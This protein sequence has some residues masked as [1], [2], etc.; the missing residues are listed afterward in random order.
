MGNSVDKIM[1]R[2][3]FVYTCYVDAKGKKEYL[4]QKD[5]YNGLPEGEKLLNEAEFIA[6]FNKPSMD[7]KLYERFLKY[8][9]ENEG[10][11]LV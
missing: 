11:Y 10:E 3:S 5:R 9:E 7:S 4:I 1:W 2:S 8:I 6:Q